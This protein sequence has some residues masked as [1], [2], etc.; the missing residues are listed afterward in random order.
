MG[1][2]S[3]TVTGR[4]IQQASARSEAAV[5]FEHYTNQPIQLTHPIL[6][7]LAYC[8]IEIQSIFE[9]ATSAWALAS[10]LHQA[11]LSLSKDVGAWPLLAIVPVVAPTYVAKADLYR[12]FDAM[13]LMLRTLGLTPTE[14][15]SL[16][17]GEA[18]GRDIPPYQKAW[19]YRGL[20]S[21]EYTLLGWAA[22]VLQHPA[23]N[24]LIKP[25]QP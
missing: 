21:I 15:A 25:V 11:A 2:S 4:L 17:K 3:R 1:A 10:V 14:Q 12:A 18:I 20:D 8:L 24:L 16:F 5:V 7:R 13:K 23:T 6:K 19:I 9:A 22:K